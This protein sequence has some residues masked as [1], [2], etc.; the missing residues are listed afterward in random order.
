M[1]VIIMGNLTVFK[2]H[3]NWS[4]ARARAILSLSLRPSGRE[5]LFLLVCFV[6]FADIIFMFGNE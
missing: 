1:P 4:R 5:A 6:C 2:G 3:L